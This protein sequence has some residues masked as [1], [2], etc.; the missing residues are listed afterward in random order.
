MIRRTPRSTRTDTL[1][2]YTTLFRFIAHDIVRGLDRI[3]PVKFVEDV[4]APD[5]HP[6]FAVRSLD[7][8]VRVDERVAVNLECGLVLRADIDRSDGLRRS[9]ERRVGKECVS[10]CSCWWCT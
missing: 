10:T 1:F 4:L 9:E 7:T 2:P 3:R 5:T 6:P 8:D